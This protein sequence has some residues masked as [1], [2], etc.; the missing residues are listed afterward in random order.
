VYT[1]LGSLPWSL[2]LT[3]VG[4]LLGEHWELLEP[5]FRR[6]DVLV[7]LGLAGLLA[8]YCWRRTRA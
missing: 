4:Y 5:W 2:L 1:F 7:L 3:Y 8:W 6:L